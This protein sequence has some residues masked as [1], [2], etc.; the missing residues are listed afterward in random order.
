M[1]NTDIT[2]ES[3]TNTTS[4]TNGTSDGT[5]V[6]DALMNTTVLYLEDQYTRGR[7]KG[8]D[9]ANVMLGAIQANTTEALQFVLQEKQLEANIDKVRQEIEI[10]KRGVGMPAYSG[11]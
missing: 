3:L 10:G 5:G 7:I 6:F 11:S 1:D 2:I 9:Y 4:V 8:T